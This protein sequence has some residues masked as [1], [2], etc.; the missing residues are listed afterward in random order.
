[1]FYEVTKAVFFKKPHNQNNLKMLKE[2]LQ[3]KYWE[4]RVFNETSKTEKWLAEGS[5]NAL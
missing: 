4:Y 2:I 5:L 1:M 3:S